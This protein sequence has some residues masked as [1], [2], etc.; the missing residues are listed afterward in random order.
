MTAALTLIAF[1]AAI[2]AVIV[3]ECTRRI[4]TEKAKRYLGRG[5]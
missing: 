1:T 4:I 3:I 2:G 5:L